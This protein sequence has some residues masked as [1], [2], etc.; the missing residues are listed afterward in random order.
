MTDR[1]EQSP[2]ALEPTGPGS[3]AAPFTGSPA[4]AVALAFSVLLT[5]ILVA[6]AIKLRRGR[7]ISPGV[8]KAGSEGARVQP[9]APGDDANALFKLLFESHPAPTWAFDEDSLR[10]VAVNDAVLRRF[11]YTRERFLQLGVRDVCPE[12]DADRIIAGPSGPLPWHHR[13]ASGALVPIEVTSHRVTAGGQLVRLVVASDATDR[14]KA[15]GELRERDDL[16]QNVL[17]SVPC[18]VFWKDRASIYIGCNDQAARD[19]GRTVPGEVIGQTDYDLA[20]EPGEAEGVRASDRQVIESA[21][22][23]L[24]VEEVRTL[25][26]GT[27]AIFLTNR[28]PLRDSAGR[29]IGVVGVSQNVT[30]RKRL[31]DELRHAQKMEAIGRLAGGV[32]H[33]FNNLLTIVTGS[34]HLIRALPPGDPKI[35]GYVD[36]I[37]AAVDRATGL[38]RQLLAFSRKQPSRPEVLDLNAVVS[39]LAGLLARLIGNRV[40]VR[41]ELAPAPVQVRADRGHLEQVLMN[42]AVNARDAMPEGGTLRITTSASDQLARLTVADT[43]VG[44]PDHVKAKIFEPFFTTKEVGKGTGLGLATVHGIVEQAGGGIE[45]ASTLGVGT[46]FHIRLPA[47]STPTPPPVATPGPAAPFAARLGRSVLLVE[48]EERVRKLVHT[49]LEGWGYAVTEADR[50]ETALALLA[51]GREI[52]L[53]VTDLVMPGM[54]GRELATRVRSLRPEV[55]VVFVSGFVPDLRRAE[56]FSDGVFLPKPFAPFDLLRCAE[57]ALRQR[58]ATNVRE[59]LAT[60]APHAGADL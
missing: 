34:V 6:A 4:G 20:R 45:V 15:E 16:L 39:E 18:A 48:D 7:R 52:D 36:E 24:D 14:R 5:L 49:T 27:R 23:L 22:P 58:H 32:A 41:T 19:H 53:L 55:A 2:T 29:V 33:D 40:A 50:A 54:D 9:P 57:R 47:C 46:T 28:V 13:I 25:A 8:T 1:S 51:T 31:E 42:L 3:V 37:Q 35:G 60:S 59:L 26:D 11:G 56:G 44:M 38:T 30:G 10:F 12:Q 43:G 17:A 21:Q